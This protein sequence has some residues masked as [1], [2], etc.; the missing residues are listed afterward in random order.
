VVAAP[1]EAIRTKHDKTVEGTSGWRVF[2]SPLRKEDCEALPVFA[3]ALVTM[4]K[5]TH[6]P[7]PV[8]LSPFES[9]EPSNDRERAI[10]KMIQD[11]CCQGG[12][13]FPNILPEVIER[14]D[15]LSPQDTLFLYRYV[16]ECC[17]PAKE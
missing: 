2:S 11:R 17:P 6:Y 13:T 12:C 9:M 16:K 15:S 14:V 8:L 4:L 5:S 10:A 3:S 1:D 7:N